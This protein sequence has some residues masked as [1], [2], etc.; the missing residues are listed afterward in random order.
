MARQPDSISVTKLDAA[1]R[2]LETAER[3]WFLE[4]DPASI[5]TLAAAAH[6][7]VHDI[8][9]KAGDGATLLDAKRHADQAACRLGL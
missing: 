8:A 2:Q 9:E 1:R 4:D 6:R 3:L 5:H 7:V